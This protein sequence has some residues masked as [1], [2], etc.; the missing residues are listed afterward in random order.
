MSLIDDFRKLFRKKIKCGKVIEYQTNT[1]VFK[2]ISGEIPGVGTIELGEVSRETQKIHT[3]AELAKA[4]DDYQ[5]LACQDLNLI[6]R[7]DPEWMATVKFRA[8]AL[9]CITDARVLIEAFKKD[10]RILADKFDSLLKDMARLR[11]SAVQRGTDHRT[12]GVSTEDL[13]SV[14]KLKVINPEPASQILKSVGL[15]EKDLVGVIKEH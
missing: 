1:I 8:A 10:P 2:A 3:A 5:Y 9:W 11:E 15:D 12:K 4:L 6:P 14:R 7:E 13:Q